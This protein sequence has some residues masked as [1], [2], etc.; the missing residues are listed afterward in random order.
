MCTDGLH[1]CSS[2]DEIFEVIS[3]ASIEDAVKELKELALD[4]GGYDNITLAVVENS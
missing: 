4:K 3:S 2:N 1:G